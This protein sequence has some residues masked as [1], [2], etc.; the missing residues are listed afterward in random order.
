ML[1]IRK[2]ILFKDLS[3]EWLEMK[4]TK[5]KYSTYIKYSNLIDYHLVPYFK[6]YELTKINSVIIRKFIEIKQNDLSLS[7]IKTL[8]YILKS[9]IEFTNKKYRLSIRI[10]NIA[11]PSYHKQIK[12]LDSHAKQLLEEYCFKHDSVVSLA[13]LL[14]LYGG[15]RIGEICALKSNNID[16]ERGIIYI[17]QTVQRIKSPNNSTKKTELILSSPKTLTSNRIVPLPNFICLFIK[18]HY[19]SFLNHE[20]LLSQKIHPL[21]PRYIQKKFKQLCKQLN[22][23]I[24]FHVLRHTYATFCVQQGV[25]IKSLSEIMGHSNPNITLSLYV[26]TS[27]EFKIHQIQKIDRT[28]NS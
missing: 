8:I 11:L 19:Q 17:D 6:E 20:F 7:T 23:E 22:I 14:S 1:R 16:L 3:N 9:L 15:L 10:D 4:K 28:I 5:I 18:E 13:I 21:D 26:H 27:D 2:K 24:N 25:D 12:V